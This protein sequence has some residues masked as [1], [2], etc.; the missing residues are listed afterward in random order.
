MNF[1]KIGIT[2]LITI[3][4]F[5]LC[6]KINAADISQFSP[7]SEIVNIQRSDGRSAYQQSTLFGF[8][9]NQVSMANG[10]GQMLYRSDLTDP[11]TSLGELRYQDGCDDIEGGYQ[12]GENVLLADERTPATIYVM[13]SADSL[14]K[15]T[16]AIESFTL[17]GFDETR[18]SYGIE[19]IA[20]LQDGRFVAVKQNAPARIAVFDYVAGTANYNPVD[21]FSFNGQCTNIGD[22]TVRPNGNLIVICKGQNNLQEYTISGALVSTLPITLDQAEGVMEENGEICVLGEPAQYQC[23]SSGDVVVDPD[24]IVEEVCTI[25]SKDVV[26]LVDSP[27]VNTT[28]DV[29]CETFN[30]TIDIDSVIN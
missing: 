25:S 14:N 21:L 29:T 9:G 2:L 17:S 6:N 13:P 8:N 19:G 7:T 12:F 24:P 5:G 23:F 11:T 22:V 20:V 27:R 10:G 28:L 16:Q 4:V 18:G 30:G 26:V 3:G 15:C 1:K